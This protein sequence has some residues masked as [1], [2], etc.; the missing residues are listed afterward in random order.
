METGEALKRIETARVELAK[1]VVKFD[2]IVDA[3]PL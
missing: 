2:K 3:S 1:A